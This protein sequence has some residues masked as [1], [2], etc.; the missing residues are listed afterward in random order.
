MTLPA[1]RS[2]P[3]RQSGN[4][5]F[6]ILIAV[7][8]FAALSYAVSGERTGT[9]DITEDKANLLASQVTNYGT[10][11]AAA[12][13]RLKN[14]GGCT[15]EMLS[16]ENPLVSGYTNP[17]APADKHCHIFHPAGGNLSFQNKF[18]GI[19]TKT[20]ISARFQ[21]NGLYTATTTPGNLYNDLALYMLVDDKTCIAVNKLMGFSIN[22]LAIENQLPTTQYWTGT[23]N[24]SPVDGAP[25]DGETVSGARSFYMRGHISACWKYGGDTSTYIFYHVLVAR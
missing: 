21:I 12:V 16:F 3:C 1:L 5:L 7:L 14:I 25:D 15:D 17:N 22:G 9:K 24:M 8:L 18:A 2:P 23:F 11:V 19:D 20:L 10:S 4:V 13:L 6:L